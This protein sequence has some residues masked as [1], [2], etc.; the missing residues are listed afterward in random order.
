MLEMFFE[1]YA[2]SGHGV[3]EWYDICYDCRVTVSFSYG[4]YGL[5]IDNIQLGWTYREYELGQETELVKQAKEEFEMLCGIFK[6]E[7]T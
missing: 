4:M 1:T 3:V 5:E 2:D 7:L 6:Q